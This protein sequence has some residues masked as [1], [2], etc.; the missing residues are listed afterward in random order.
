MTK[1]QG[2]Q[3]MTTVFVKSI[4]VNHNPCDLE[5][6]VNITMEIPNNAVYSDIND[7]LFFMD[8]KDL[9]SYEFQ[10][11]KLRII[12]DYSWEQ[13]RELTLKEQADNADTTK[14]V[15]EPKLCGTIDPTIY[16]EFS[17]LGAVLVETGPYEEL[18]D[19]FPKGFSSLIKK[20]YY[21]PIIGKLIGIFQTS[22]AEYEYEDVPSSLILEWLRCANKGESI[23]RFY[24]QN[25]R[26]KFSPA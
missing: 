15:A 25:I 24:L 14:T 20:A 8:N 10:T 17:K 1:I 11:Q 23:G 7:S 9:K 4:A 6:D 5:M 18:Y 13:D 12:K 2:N 3:P 16:D 22:E 19:L 21:C 26:G